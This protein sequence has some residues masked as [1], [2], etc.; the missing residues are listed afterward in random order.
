MAAGTP[1]IAFPAGELVNAI[2]HARTGWLVSSVAEMAAAMSRAHEIAPEVCRSE[3]RERFSREAMTAK[4]LALYRQR[5][6]P[7]SRID[8]TW[9]VLR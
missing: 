8:V 3:A 5:S 2:D 4:Y 7:A 1:V 6:Y 9:K